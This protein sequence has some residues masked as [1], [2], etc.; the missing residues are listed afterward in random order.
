MSDSTLARRKAWAYLSRVVEGPSRNLQDLLKQGY[1]PEA[2]VQAIKNRES[3]LGALLAETESRYSWDRSDADLEL[4]SRLGGR[5]VTPDDAEWPTEVLDSAFG[6]AASGYSDHARSYQAD[7]VAPHALWVRGASL[8]QLCAQAVSLVGTRAASQY[9]KQAAQLVTAGLSDCGWTVV[10]GGALGIDTVV[11]TTALNRRGATMVVLACGID[12]YYPARNTPMLQAIADS[13]NGAVVTEYPPG[14][15]PQRHRFLTRNRLVAALSQGTVVVEAAWR[16]GALNTLS[17]A[18]AFGRV[19]MAIPGPITTPG[20]LGC[21]ERIR[22]GQ[23]QLVCSAD[24]IRELVSKIGE[25]DVGS[26][27]ELAFA[28]NEVQKLSR[29][30][31]RVFDAL[32]VSSAL[33]AEVV[34]REAGLTIKLAVHLLVGLMDRGLVLRQGGGWLRA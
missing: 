11:H 4:V 10:S 5:L 31:L 15:A 29:N 8:R 24:E 13:D 28:A 2:I 34:A 7:A 1:E 18:A 20:S 30:E 19:A 27:Y 6:F 3:W 12:R 22:N 32:S 23:A 16:S 21:H 26:Q 14:L 17:W 33:S 9:G 25:V